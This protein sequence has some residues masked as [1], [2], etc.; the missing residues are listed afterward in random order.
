MH[1]YR[2][3]P[4]LIMALFVPPGWSQSRPVSSPGASDGKAG[5]KT[6]VFSFEFADRPQIDL[7]GEWEFRRDPNGIGVS[8]GWHAGRGEFPRSIRLPGAPQAQGVGEP[9]ERQRSFF[10]EPF[11]VRRRFQAPA[12]GPDQRLWLRIGGISPAA[13]VYVNGKHIGYTKSSRTP[14]RM[15]VTRQVRSAGENLIAIHV[16]ELP[17]IRL[18]GLWEMAE[19]AMTWTGIYRSMRG[20]VAHRISLLD[21]YV[22][23]RLASGSV[24]VEAVLS[25][26]ADENLE[27]AVDVLDGTRT[28]GRT[29][30]SLRPGSDRL[31]GQVK[32]NEYETWTPEHPQLYLLRMALHPEGNTAAVDRASI[33]FGMREISPQG[34]KLLLNGRPIFVRAFGDDHYY[35]ETLCPPA[36]RQWYLTRLRTARAYGMN[37]AKGCVETMTPEYLEAADEAGILIIQEMPFG[38]SDLRAKR[39]T[40]DQPFRDF[41]SAELDGLVRWSRNHASVVAFSMSSELE[42]HN[43]TQE[44]FDFF[45]SDLVRQTRRLAPHALV[46][47][48]TG[49]LNAEDTNKG[50]RDTDFYASIC[51]TWMKKVLD[52][53]PMVTDRKHPMILHEY[54]W[55]SCY[56]DPADKARYEGMQLKSFWLDTLVRTARENGQEHLLPTYRKHSLWLQALCRKDGIEYARRNPDAEGYILWL[57]IDF[58]QYSEGLL[59]DFWQ[60]KN[61]SPREFLKSNGDTVVLLAKEGNRCLITGDRQEIPLAISHYGAQPLRGCVLHWRVNVKGKPAQ[62]GSIGVQDVA[63]GTLEAAGSAQ[64]DLQAVQ[65][66]C[67]LRLYVTLRQDGR[68]INTNDWSFWAFPEVDPAWRQPTSPAGRSTLANHGAFI[69]LADEATAAIPAGTRLILAESVD[70]PLAAFIAGGGR[71]LLLARGTAIENTAKYYG[72]TTFYNVFR[73]IPW[74]AGT[75]GNSGTV[76]ECHPSLAAFPHEQMCDLQFVWLFRDVLP[77]HFEPLRP[78]GVQPVIRMIDHHAA[79]RNN[80]HLLEFKVGEGRVLATT[81]NLLANVEQRIE[82]RSLLKCLVEYALSPEFW[83]TTSVP[84]EVLLKWFSLRPTS[85]PAK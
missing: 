61:V 46:I 22:R 49:Y 67:M 28:I 24:E 16:R 29:L 78:Y 82:A 7:D 14:Q 44:S 69:R 18:D 4:L 5:F 2:Y 54:N 79:N 42:F 40:I 32:L 68:R 56:P 36:D 9:N 84:K 19:C 38:L 51:P 31:T 70:E 57:L 74:N 1:V 35:P 23:P 30:I 72:D 60:P 59:D 64:L 45:S 63:C 75:S 10:M 8:Q 83:P 41:Y 15:D 62:E 80:A 66:P 77:M 50:K 37:A 21:A 27:L 85:A 33:R 76:I 6:D 25:A 26:P 34:T 3:A 17:E 47:D 11:W 52:E 43:Q 20:E 65:S 71:C 13:D 39:Y 73:T 12:I 55:W 53:T 81:L 58:A 48:C